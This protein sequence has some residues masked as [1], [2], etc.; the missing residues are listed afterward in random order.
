MLSTCKNTFHSLRQYL[1]CCFIFG[2]TSHV[3]LYSRL[4]CSLANEV[5]FECAIH[6]LLTRILQ[7]RNLLFSFLISHFTFLISHL[8][9]RVV[10]PPR[11]KKGSKRKVGKMKFKFM[12]SEVDLINGRLQQHSGFVYPPP[13]HPF[14][15]S[16]ASFAS[17]SGRTENEGLHGSGKQQICVCIN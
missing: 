13:S 14:F 1:E 12:L 3:L 6:M 15:L 16:G 2:Y 7:S 10:K 8:P 9:M 17:F 4:Y 5:L 11:R